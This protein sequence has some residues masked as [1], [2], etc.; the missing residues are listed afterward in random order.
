MIAASARQDIVRE[1]R[2]LLNWQILTVALLVTGYS[3]YYLCR[4]NLS[5]AMPLIVAEL[6]QHGMAASAARIA[7]GSIASLGTL[8]Y[9]LGKLPS[10]AMADVLGG[11]RNFLFG[12][13]GA[14]VFTLLFAASGAIPLFTLAWIGNRLT[15]SLGWAGAV[16]IASK[17]VSFRSYGAVMAIISLSFLF[18]DAISREFMAWL[19]AGG[20]GWRG[21]FFVGAG[22]LTAILVSCLFLLRESPL[23]IGQPEP[24]ANPTNLF[25]KEESAP[26]SLGALLLPLF[27]SPMFRWA[28]VLSLGT[29]IVKETFS[30]W[31][32]T[33]F[34][35]ATGMSASAAASNSALFPLLGGV[36]V[37]LCGWLSDRLG[38]G[39]RATVMVIGL[40]CAGVALTSLAVGSTHGSRVWTVVLVSLVAF[41]VFGPYSYLA[42]AM[43][44]DFGGKQASGTTS[45]LID[46]VGY[47]GGVVSGDSMARISID[48][49]WSGALMVLAVVA[50]LSGAAAVAFLMGERRLARA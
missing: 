35:Q 14:I 11:R 6:T 42:G 45:G 41:M 2:T 25:A 16:K 17:W 28:C 8:A 27:A 49:G 21:I 5:V 33:Y 50:F 44:M 3:G 40:M 13:A 1:K 48:F 36:S 7:L 9:A 26:R 22:V 19:I 39:G 24:S 34:V 46:C 20:M 38:R 29:T 43:S 15:Q 18:G 47:L 31:T 37:L 12:M 4:S 30:L 32:P 23:A 10:G